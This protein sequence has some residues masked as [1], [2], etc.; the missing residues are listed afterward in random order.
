MCVCVCVCT[1]SCPTLCDRLDCRPPVSSVCG[2][3]QARNGFLFPTPR[4]LPDPGIEPTY[5]ASPVLASIFFATV[6]LDIIYIFEMPF[7]ITHLFLLNVWKAKERSC[8][9]LANKYFKCHK[10]ILSCAQHLLM[11]WYIILNMPKA[12]AHIIKKHFKQLRVSYALFFKYFLIFGLNGKF[13]I[14][15][16]DLIKKSKMHKL[17]SHNIPDLLISWD[18][19]F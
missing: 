17:E 14:N 8:L 4:D 16:E 5:L 3:F 15:Y 11:F 2:I 12:E 10:F 6:P 9:N 13:C 18:A 19:Y 7:W 1:Q